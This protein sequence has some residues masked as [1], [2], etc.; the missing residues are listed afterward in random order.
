[1]SCIIVH[2][3]KKAQYYI[4]F[5]FLL[6]FFIVISCSK[7]DEIPEPITTV[8]AQNFSTLIDE[9]P[10][11][12]QVLG[13]LQANTNNGSP[14]SFNL[15][16][17]S[18]NGALKINSSTGEL[19]VKD[20]TAFDYE[21]NIK[22]TAEYIA[23][24]GT[25]KDTASVTINLND[26]DDGSSVVANDF[27]ASIDENPV[28]GATIGTLN[29]SVEGAIPGEANIIS[30]TLLSE[31]ITG[32]LNINA[33]TG[34]LSV[35]DPTVFDFET[36]TS[37][38]GT[39]KAT[40]GDLSDEA[41][42]TIT[43]NDVDDNVTFVA[44]DFTATIPENSTNGTV[45]GTVNATISTGETITFSINSQTPASAISIDA[46]TGEIKVANSTLFDY[47]TYPTITG[48]YE[49]LSNNYGSTTANITITLTNVS[50]TYWETVG[51]EGFTTTSVAYT[52][53]AFS[54]GVPMI[55]FRAT[56]GGNLASVMSY[57][58][59]NWGNVGTANFSSGE[60]NYIDFISYNN[61]EY[62]A[63]TDVAN[64]GKTTVKKY[65][66]TSWETVGMEG[67]SSGESFYVTL[68]VDGNGT[69]YVCYGDYSKSLKT[70]VRT[71]NT[72]TNTWDLV[73]AE[74]ITLGT[75]YYPEMAIDPTNN[76]PYVV[77]SDGGR[78]S[79]IVVKK[80]NGTSWVDEH[81]VTSH[82]GDG[83]I[84]FSANGTPYIVYK[85]NSNYGGKLVCQAKINGSWSIQ[86][87]AGFSAGVNNDVDLLLVDGVP[88]VAYTD[89]VY[90]QKVTVRRLVSSTWETVGSAGFST[91]SGFFPSLVKDTNNTVYVGYYDA[92]ISPTNSA[93]VKKLIEQ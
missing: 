25:V 69:I 23:S 9:N 10:L 49:V 63:Y 41:T 39:Y 46:Y 54:D 65:N 29:A 79:N 62:V 70:V 59:G 78:G 64:G 32:A 40:S 45:I 37:I 92:G 33:T 24:T 83:V 43:I 60:A 87:N 15:I 6:A 48:T 74:G 14:L 17:V 57:S 71:Y 5:I 7:D 35:A 93:V 44:N 84:N 4:V 76:T 56:S 21:K 52:K 47:E 90:S 72:A 26:L 81:L 2:V 1:M 73:G 3:L 30:F 20:S 28:S 82:T 42:I 27:S 89:A 53:M 85:D 75:G 38:T 16:N 55:A 18:S 51:T 12:G 50:E 34:V 91:G 13:S 22:I 8:V 67:F 58:N 36:N 19:S 31:S 68:A 11:N 61:T 80:F 88:Y 77:V 86:G 66:G